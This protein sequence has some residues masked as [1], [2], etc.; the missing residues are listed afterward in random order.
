MSRKPAKKTTKAHQPSRRSAKN[1][2][3]PIP[4]EGE[5]YLPLPGDLADWATV[6]HP[7]NIPP[8][9]NETNTRI[10]PAP[11]FTDEKPVGFGRYLLFLVIILFLLA[12]SANLFGR[13]IQQQDNA[14]TPTPPSS[15]PTLQNSR[16]ITVR[17]LD[18]RNYSILWLN[19]AHDENQ[20]IVQKEGSSNWL[21]I[22]NDD[23][24]VIHGA[25]DPSGQN[26]AYSSGKDDGQIVIRSIDGRTTSII[27]A[28]QIKDAGIAAKIDKIG[29][30]PWSPVAWSPSGSRVAFYG[31]SPHNS[32]S[33]V[34]VA[35]VHSPHSAPSIIGGLL[36]NGDER[37]LFWLDDH[38]ILT[39]RPTRT[40]PTVIATIE[41]P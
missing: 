21:L 19:S 9:A 27:A 36:D 1:E 8:T 18:V 31:C 10:D 20:L 16:S 40:T 38:K 41:A 26:V 5:P 39:T 30:C 32:F 14:Q 3:L 15:T 22:S 28:S 7:A 24:A 17:I 12:G 33:T 37:Q 23:T 13:Y 11:G 25:L 4:G 6:P 35:E 29:L 2:G 34:L